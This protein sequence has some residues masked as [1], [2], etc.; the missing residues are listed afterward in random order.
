MRWLA[1]RLVFPLRRAAGSRQ[2]APHILYVWLNEE[3]FGMVTQRIKGKQLAHLGL[4]IG[5]AFLGLL[6]AGLVLTDVGLAAPPE[7]APPGSVPH[8]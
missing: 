4:S 8:S 6:I 5:V 2:G 7:S 1:E 3:G